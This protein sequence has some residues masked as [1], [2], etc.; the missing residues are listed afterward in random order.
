[1]NWLERK[2][3][4]I[5]FPSIIRYLAFF[6]LGVL[7]LSFA[8]P[9]AAKLLA[10]NWPLILEGQL[11]RLVTFIFMPL[12]LISWGLNMA[13]IAFSIIGAFLLITF[14]D[15]LENA[16][17]SF[18]VTLYF[19]G[20][21]LSAV[22]ASVAYCLMGPLGIV[23]HTIPPEMLFDYSIIFAF[24]VFHPRYELRLMMIFPVPIFIIAI[25]SGLSLL[26]FL[27][28]G[29]PFFLFTLLCLSHFFILVVPMIINRGKTKKH[30][31]K[32]SA[33]KEQPAH[34]HECAVCKTTDTQDATLSFRVR[35][36]G[37]EICDNCRK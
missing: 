36:D 4:W 13:G 9:S 34:F 16:M 33:L 30:K 12:G 18:K 24:A 7:A 8:N 28:L 10:F 14:S 32:F 11:W 22:L 1:M 26:F 37:S 23:P 31:V 5:A 17:G 19:L 20:G 25:V 2:M 21:W 6:Q 3:G 29:L 15:G 35:S 27:K